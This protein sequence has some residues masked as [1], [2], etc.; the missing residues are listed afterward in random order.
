MSSVLDEA[1]RRV[2]SKPKANDISPVENQ[3]QYSAAASTT[4]SRQHDRS[5]YQY[6][7]KSPSAAL[8]SAAC[9]TNGNEE[10]VAQSHGIPSDS[11]KE[12]AAKGSAKGAGWTENPDPI[13]RVETVVRTSVAGSLRLMGAAVKGVGEAVFQAGAV[14]EGLAGGTGMVAGNYSSNGMIGWLTDAFVDCCILS[15]NMFSNYVGGSSWAI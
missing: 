9:D 4:T 8:G 5:S 6:D 11:G 1:S 15:D 14:A 7:G 13:N 3:D 2:D 10:K 12:K